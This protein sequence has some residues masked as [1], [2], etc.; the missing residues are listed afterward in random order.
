MEQQGTGAAYAV[1]KGARR[2]RLSTDLSTVK[3]RSLRAAPRVVEQ[4]RELRLRSEPGRK[5]AISLEDWG[6]PD[7]RCAPMALLPAAFGAR[8]QPHLVAS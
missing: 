8:P 5:N 4:T 2:R 3:E 1:L 6:F 7:H